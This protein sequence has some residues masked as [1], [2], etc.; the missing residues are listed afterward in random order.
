MVDRFH[1]ILNEN[2][3]NVMEIAAQLSRVYVFERKRINGCKWNIFA[4]CNSAGVS[5]CAV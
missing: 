1:L 4:D 2:E 3:C 5:L